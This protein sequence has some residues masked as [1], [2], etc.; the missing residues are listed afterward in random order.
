MLSSYLMLEMTLELVFLSGAWSP[1]PSPRVIGRIC[2]LVAAGLSPNL[3]SAKEHFLLQDVTHGFF[4][5]GPHI[6]NL[7]FCFSS[8]RP[9]SVSLS[10]SFVSVRKIS[11]LLKHSLHW[12]RL[13]PGTLSTAMQLDTIRVIFH[14]NHG[15]HPY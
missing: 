5:H 12:V 10:A 6:H 11:L 15:L 9:H 8:S 7:D 2:F 1:L 13:T 3:P 14:H 4:L